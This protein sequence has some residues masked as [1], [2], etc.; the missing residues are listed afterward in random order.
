MY[1][2]IHYIEDLDK[3]RILVEDIQRHNRTE[4]NG[5]PKYELSKRYS[6]I[7]TQEH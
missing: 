6:N 3:K 7:V 5:I 1:E 2:I 4:I